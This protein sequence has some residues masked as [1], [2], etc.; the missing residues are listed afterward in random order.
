MDQISRYRLP[1]AVEELAAR[2]PVS[3]GILTAH[4]ASLE[5]VGGDGQRA[6]LEPR[7]MQVLLV[8]AD[9]GSKTV[10]RAE[11]LDRFW[12]GRIVDD[13]ALNRVIV[14]LRRVVGEVGGGLSIVTVPRVGY[15]LDVE[16]VPSLPDAAPSTGHLPPVDRGRRRVLAVA[17]ASLVALVGGTVL[18]LPRARPDPASI[19]ASNLHERARLLMSDMTPQ[20]DAEAVALLR[21]ATRLDPAD[22]SI[23]GTLALA[24]QRLAEMGREEDA[25]AAEARTRE[26][27]GQA[28]ARDPG[29]ADAQVAL[30][31][32]MPVYRNWQRAEDAY[33]NLLARF[34][35]H[36]PLLAGRAKMLAEVGRFDEAMAAMDRV[37]AIEPNG[38]AYHWR[39]ALGLW[40]AGRPEAALA[41]ITRA[42]RLWPANW[43]VNATSFWL[44]LY[45]GH[46][47]AALGLLAEL[48][49]VLP[50]QAQAFMQRSAEALR[51]RNPAFSQSTL[52]ENRV[53]A[54]TN[55]NLAE[56][57]MAVA[58]AL[59]SLEEVFLLAN[60]YHFGTGF[61]VAD[62]R[63]E[64][65][66]RMPPR[67]RKTLPLFWP[68]L[69]P[70]RA[71]PRFGQLTQAVGLEGYW[72]STGRQPDFRRNLL[73]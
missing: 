44:H 31:L 59:G 27:A 34:P 10:T 3:L 24:H 40:S 21:E 28:L 39:K 38:S 65:G 71:D 53:A 25:P 37:F 48:H 18:L 26:A 6:H 23:L 12:A 41:L 64:A 5:L 4:P 1:S 69:A 17:T 19:E 7:M 8:L 70:A 62:T 36:A 60:A 33:T 63:L 51:D 20:R 22:A 55:S 35:D 32:A 57:A 52:A 58:G 14:Q 16:Q 43:G 54:A 30:V 49:A 2:E 73:R 66:E 29:N 9:A 15:R 72:A 13:S 56:Q 42:R 67:R 46:P 47:D 11:L 45:T 61:T 50:P 68:P